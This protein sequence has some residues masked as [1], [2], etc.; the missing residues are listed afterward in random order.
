MAVGSGTAVGGTAVGGTA[1]GSAGTTGGSGAAVGA[2]VQADNAITATII[3][4]IT[5]YNFDL[6]VT[7]LRLNREIEI[8]P[9]LV[10]SPPIFY[11]YKKV[12]ASRIGFLVN[13][14]RIL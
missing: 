12:Y 13:I 5:I 2:G 10:L 14:L 3:T 1:V 7:S 11:T 6:I 8:I 4:A 9:N